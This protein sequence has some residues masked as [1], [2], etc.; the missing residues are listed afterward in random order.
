VRFVS[1]EYYLLGSPAY[2]AVQRYVATTAPERLVE[3]RR[4]LRAIRPS[5]ANM[6]EHVEWYLSVPDKEQYLRHARRVYKLV[7]GVAHRPGTAPTPWPCTTLARSCRSTSTTACPNRRPATAWC[8]GTPTRPEI[9]SGGAASPATRSPTGGP[10]LTPPT[11]PRVRIAVPPDPTWHYATAGSYLRRWYGRRYVSIGFTFDHGMVS[12]GPGA[13]VT[14]PP[15]AP[16]WSERPLGRVDL[17]Q[18][19][20]DLHTPAPAPVQRWL[21]AP[22]RTRGLPDRG[23]SSFMAGGSLAQWFDVIVHCQELTPAHR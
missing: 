8:I 5:T 3:L 9:S 14:L 11:P 16:G 21:H 13:T 19:A 4:D 17:D 1:V 12:L 18:F 10:A 23:P 2:D 22:I 20:L 7:K 15:P 6:F